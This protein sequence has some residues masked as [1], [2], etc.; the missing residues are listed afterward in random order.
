MRILA[1][2]MR[3]RCWQR[4]LRIL[5]LSRFTEAVVI[6]S[7][8]WNSSGR[9][10]VAA[11]WGRWWN[12]GW[13]HCEVGRR[14]VH[15]SHLIRNWRPLPHGMN[16]KGRSRQGGIMRILSHRMRRKRRSMLILM[17][18]WRRSVHQRRY[19]V[20]IVVVA[21]HAVAIII[22]AIAVILTR[23]RQNSFRLM[24]IVVKDIVR[25]WSRL[26]RLFLRRW[27]F[28]LRR[29]FSQFGHKTQIFLIDLCLI[30]GALDASQSGSFR[31]AIFRNVTGATARRTHNV[32]SNIGLIGAQET[33]VIGASTVRASRTISLT[34]GSV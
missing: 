10:Q 30:V 20:R 25:S 23:W 28:L 34:Q 14:S 29:N 8:E 17:P 16:R 9:C 11:A 21:I 5:S 26:H 3:R 7:S 32:V 31:L 19:V 15:I 1:Q 4:W 6:K 13:T 27:R 18:R 2:W 33:L 12:S 24:T 22:V